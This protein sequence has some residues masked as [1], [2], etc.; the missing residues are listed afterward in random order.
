M[1]SNRMSPIIEDAITRLSLLTD[2][3]RSSWRVSACG[4]GGQSVSY[5]ATTET[6]AFCIKTAD[7]GSIHLRREAFFLSLIACRHVPRLVLDCSEEGFVVE[8]LIDGLRLFELSAEERLRRLPQIASALEN[9]TAIFAAAKPAIVHRDLKP[10]N[11]VVTQD[12]LVIVLDFGSA[13]EEGGRLHLERGAR[14]N[15]LGTGTHQA[16]PL[17]QLVGSVFQDRRVDIF[18]AASIIFWIITGAA[19]YQNI[20]TECGNAFRAYR[21][22]EKGLPDRLHDLPPALRTELEAALRVNPATRPRS[23]APLAAAVRDYAANES[24][25]AHRHY[26]REL[27]AG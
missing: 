10:A 5:A 27:P 26:C 15:K 22:T 13:E 17:E 4:S 6:D 21:E 16:Q 23:L 18:A 3:H 19:P 11:L 14:R 1:A 2:T 7:P 9:V 24:H 12:G 8:Q 20:Y 25:V